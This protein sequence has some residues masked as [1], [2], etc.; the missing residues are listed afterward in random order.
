MNDKAPPTVIEFCPF[1]SLV[2]KLSQA[3]IVHP[4]KFVK[5]KHWAVFDLLTLLTKFCT[6]STQPRKTR[7]RT[8]EQNQS[9][10]A[11][12][13]ICKHEW[14]IRELRKSEFFQSVLAS[15]DGCDEIDLHSDGSWE[16]VVRE[17]EVIDLTQIVKCEP[18]LQ[19]KAT[20]RS[21]QI[22]G[23]LSRIGKLEKEKA[24]AIKR[25]TIQIDELRQKLETER[26]KRNAKEDE[27]TKLR[28]QVEQQVILAI[29]LPLPQYYIAVAATIAVARNIAVANLLL[30]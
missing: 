29:L 14:P 7:K 8:R 16:A 6:E 4:G 15:T 17:E 27:L 13:P 12:C 2:C 26:V 21:K 18:G 20:F 28:E 1:K 22:S 3:R 5:C 9:P 10:K 23:L 30:C 25:A 11:E 24:A 19:N